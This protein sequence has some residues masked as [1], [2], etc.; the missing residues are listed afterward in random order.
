MTTQDAP[1]ARAGRK[2]SFGDTIGTAHENVFRRFPRFAKLAA[3]PFL[4][5][6]A[7]TV[8]EFPASQVVPASDLLFLVLD[9]LPFALLGVAVSRAV[10]TGEDVG[11]LPPQPFGRRLWVYTGYALLMTVMVFVPL[12][13][14]ILGVA[15]AAIVTGGED[16]GENSATWMM[17]GGAIGFFAVLYVLARLSLVF[18]ALSVD[19]RLGLA[20]SWRLSRGCGLRLVGILLA[21]LAFTALF[22][23]VGSAVL[24]R[25][26]S[27]N[28]GGGIEIPPG[29]SILEVLIA[30]APALVW[31]ALVSVCSFGLTT[32]AYASA[33]AQLSG[34]GAPR[35]EILERFE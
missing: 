18:P 33:Y 34:W 6:L 4:L 12:V 21:I 16:L 24:G 25:S 30:E 20:G 5:G 28:I 14:L 11:F 15:G 22:A 2:L 7:L 35:E 13:V 1:A 17:L 19:E 32:A 23:I 29:A 9:L 3:V 27:I 8:L 26:I 10:L 31:S